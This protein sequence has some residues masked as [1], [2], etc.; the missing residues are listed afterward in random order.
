M[1]RKGLEERKND[2]KGHLV[3]ILGTAKTEKREL[4]ENEKSLFNDLEREVKEIDETLKREEV[5][6]TME[7]K[8]TETRATLEERN[9]RVCRLHK[10]NC[11]EQSRRV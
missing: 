9:Q 6:N 7:N 4:T 8:N 5:K 3:N 10:S 11:R 1:N 2:L